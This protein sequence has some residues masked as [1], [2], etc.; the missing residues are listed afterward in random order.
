M[1]REYEGYLAIRSL[2]DLDMDLFRSPWVALDGVGDGGVLRGTI[3]DRGTTSDR[4]NLGVGVSS[5]SFAS[6]R[7]LAMFL[8]RPVNFSRLVWLA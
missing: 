6:E 5:L 4:A 8:S 1:S 3:S 2:R 7:E